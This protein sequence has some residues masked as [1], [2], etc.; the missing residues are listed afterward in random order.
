[1]KLKKTLLIL[2]LFSLGTMSTLNAR[3]LFIFNS[4]DEVKDKIKI[5]K[6]GD[7]AL[8]FKDGRY[9]RYIF[10]GNKFVALVDNNV[11]DTPNIISTTALRSCKDIYD[12]GK[13]YGD[14]Y[15][16]IDPDGEGGNPPFQVYCD[17]TNGGWTLVANI[18]KTNEKEGKW[19]YLS[20]FW[21]NNN[22]GATES[23]FFDK[24]SK[25]KAWASVKANSLKIVK[26]K[27]TL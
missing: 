17:M 23:K 20:P 16:A 27:K 21:E 22:N 8:F 13:S 10:D 3:N 25:T 26:D 9:S 5:A 1:M 11:N 12:K 14:G 4:Q 6:K 7:F 24:N 18:V 19:S 15:Y 2:S